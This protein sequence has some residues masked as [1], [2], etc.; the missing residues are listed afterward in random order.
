MPGDERHASFSDLRGISIAHPF[1]TLL[2]RITGGPDW[3]D[4]ES[5]NIEAKAETYRASQKLT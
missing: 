3:M 1:S 4:K 5:F 2:Q